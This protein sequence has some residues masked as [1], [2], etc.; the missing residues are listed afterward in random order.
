MTL[1]KM[2][3]LGNWVANAHRCGHDDDPTL[4]EY[5]AI[6]DYLYSLAPQFGLPKN[7]EY[8]LEF[9]D[10]RYADELLRLREEYDDEVFWTELCDRLGERD[11]ER[12]YTPEERQQMDEVEHFERLETCIIAL[13][14]ETEEHGLERLE[15][16]KT[17]EDLG[18]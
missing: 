11:F 9:G 13:E 6:A 5:N 18:L 14:E 17:L 7:I 2:A 12:R 15:F 16:M 4:P 8:E 10:T 1:V 3:Y